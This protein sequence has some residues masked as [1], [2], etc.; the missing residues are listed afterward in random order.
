MA[1]LRAYRHFVT[2]CEP[3]NLGEDPELLYQDIWACPAGH[4][5]IWRNFTATLSNPFPDGEEPVYY[6]SVLPPGGIPYLLHWHW[7]VDHTA[8]LAIKQLHET[9][10][11]MVVFNPGDL[12]R[13][14][15]LCSKQL[16]I[17]ASGHLLPLPAAQLRGVE[18][19]NT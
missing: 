14:H 13:V 10:D 17:S 2:Y 4:K 19:R 1:I 5:A 12:V 8:T 15:N 9:W 11:C 16:H 3:N 7:W 18:D 6:I